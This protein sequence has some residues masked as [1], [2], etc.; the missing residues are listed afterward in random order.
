MLIFQ[1]IRFAPP[2]EGAI[3]ESGMG[4]GC[5]FQRPDGIDM[6]AGDP[7]DAVEGV[8]PLGQV[9]EVLTV[10]VPFR[11]LVGGLT[12]LPFVQLLADPQPTGGRVPLPLLFAQAAEPAGPRVIGAVPAEDVMHLVDEA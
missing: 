10:P 8:H 2:R 12:R 6:V 4:R 1:Y 7:A 3:G 9:M 11:P 5:Q